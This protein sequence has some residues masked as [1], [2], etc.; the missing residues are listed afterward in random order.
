MMMIDRGQNT[1]EIAA[2]RGRTGS[3]ALSAARG[4]HETNRRSRAITASASDLPDVAARFP[5]LRSQEELDAMSR[6][7]WLARFWRW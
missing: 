6:R 1:P 2:N 3:K 4:A 7:G 5:V